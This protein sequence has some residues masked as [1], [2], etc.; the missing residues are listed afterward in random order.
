LSNR[1]P[2]ELRMSNDVH[3]YVRVEVTTQL[4]GS[5]FDRARWLSCDIEVKC[6]AL[7]AQMR[8]YRLRAEAL[9]RF[10]E[11]V[12][13]LHREL[14]G[15]VTLSGDDE[16]FSL[17]FEGD[18]LGHIEVGGELS[19]EPFLDAGGHFTFTFGSDQT[20]LRRFIVGLDILNRAYPDPD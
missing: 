18:G 17:S 8:G 15:I 19:D 13:E 7:T 16:R 20:F 3:D 12:R 6:G 9:A 2:L 1:K 11:R 4:P 14:S 5:S 10:R